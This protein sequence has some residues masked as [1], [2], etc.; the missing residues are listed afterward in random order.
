MTARGCSRSVLNAF[1]S[2][3]QDG[4]SSRGSCNGGMVMRYG[5]QRRCA[6]STA[7]KLK[8]T[9]RKT[10]AA[11]ER[12]VCNGLCSRH[13]FSCQIAR[14]PGSH[15]AQASGCRRRSYRGRRRHNGCDLLCLLILRGRPQGVGVWRVQGRRGW[16]SMLEARCQGVR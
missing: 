11:G 10:A 8:L 14:C 3:L 9:S 15:F 13:H 4:G 2:S 7:M 5:P 16:D 12:Q 6:S 1:L